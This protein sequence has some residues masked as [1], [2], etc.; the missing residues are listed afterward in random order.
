MSPAS[1]T[2]WMQ[3]GVDE[4]KQYSW[5]LQPLDARGF[6]P[7]TRAAPVHEDGGIVVDAAGVQAPA[8]AGVGRLSWRF[9]AQLGMAAQ[10]AMGTAGPAHEASH[11]VSE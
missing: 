3:Y 7:Q 5:A 6:S 10:P 9:S 8:S 4:G 1:P 11:V 2:N